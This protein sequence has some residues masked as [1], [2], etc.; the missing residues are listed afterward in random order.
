M[1]AQP[2]MKV[3]ELFEDAHAP[4]MVSMVGKILRSG[5]RVRALLATW[6][7]EKGGNNPPAYYIITAITNE[8]DKFGNNQ[9][10]LH[11]E[12]GGSSFA[13]WFELTDEDDEH[14]TLKKQEDGTYLLRNKDGKPIVV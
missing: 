4:L 12:D 1:G 6:N 10:R 5:G 3:T 7:N 2:A 9:W 8:N 14:M 11:Y 13:H